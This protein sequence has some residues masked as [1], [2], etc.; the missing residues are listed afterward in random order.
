MEYTRSRKNEIFNK[1]DSLK[2]L[3][4]RNSVLWIY[5]YHVRMIDDVF[6]DLK[7]YPKDRI[8]KLLKVFTFFTYFW[9]FNDIKNETNK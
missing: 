2:W 3:E 4:K 8:F 5:F 1:Y 7:L 6:N 9:R